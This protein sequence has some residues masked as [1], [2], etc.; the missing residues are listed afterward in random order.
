MIVP[1]ME[2]GDVARE[3]AEGD[4]RLRVVEELSHRWLG[5]KTLGLLPS[6]KESKGMVNLRVDADVRLHPKAVQAIVET[7]KEI[8]GNVQ[9]FG[10]WIVEGFWEKVLV[11]AVGW[12]IRGAVDLDR[13]NDISQIEAFANGQCIAMQRSAYFTIEDTSLFA[14]K[15]LKMFVLPKWSSVRGWLYK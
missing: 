15:C 13:V 5:W 4:S 8:I 9:F 12:L 3:G 2:Q 11:P 14:I 6:V 1:M 10:T 7:A